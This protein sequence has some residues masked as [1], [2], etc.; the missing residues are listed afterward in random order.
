MKISNRSGF[1]LV[2][3]AIALLVSSIILLPLFGIIR[4][5]QVKK[6]TLIETKD[7]S[8]QVDP[9]PEFP[10]CIVGKISTL[11]V[12]VPEESAYLVV[13]NNEDN[14]SSYDVL[15]MRTNLSLGQKVE[16]RDVG[17]KK[18][19]TNPPEA[20]FKITRVYDPPR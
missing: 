11:P 7:V 17:F 18:K 5:K 15:T 9:P 4:A 14:S 19:G 1:T 3:V 10:R 8:S 16:I 20:A 13:V 2:E 6:E 12:R